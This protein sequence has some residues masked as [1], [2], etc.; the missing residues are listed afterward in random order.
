MLPNLLTDMTV[1]MDSIKE[2]RPRRAQYQLVFTTGSNSIFV[3]ST[4]TMELTWLN[5]ISVTIVAAHGEIDNN[6]TLSL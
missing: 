3:D 2:Q 4:L 1:E 6:G 5:V